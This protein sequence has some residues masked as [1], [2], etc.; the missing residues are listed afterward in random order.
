MDVFNITD[1]F[2]YLSHESYVEIN[3]AQVSA[4]T[5]I[6][7]QNFNCRLLGTMIIWKIYIITYI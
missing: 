4:T 7:H 2:V 6:Y 1:D 5:W 3:F